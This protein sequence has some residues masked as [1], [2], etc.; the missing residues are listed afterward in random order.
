MSARSLRAAF[1]A[2]LLLIAT[3]SFAQDASAPVST[4]SPQEQRH[5]GQSASPSEEDHSAHQ[6]PADQNQYPAEIPPITDQDRVAAFPKLHGQQSVHDDAV[7]YYVLFDQLEWQT[8][9]GS[10]AGSWDNQGWIGHDINRFWFRAEGEA[11]RGGVAD[12]FADALFGRAIRPFWD[13]V[14]GVRQ[15]F[16]PGPG[17]TWAAVGIQ[18]LAPYW[19]EVEATAY[20]GESWRT[21]FRLE[22]E[23]ELLLTNR[24]I[25]QPRLEFDIYGKSDPER[26]IGAGLSSGEAG[27][28]LRY[29]LRREFAP[30]VGVTWDRSFFGTADLA[31][32]SGEDTD[33]AKL[34]LGRR[35][36][37]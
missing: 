24:L 8:A 22:T 27:L 33:G 7:H 31:Q 19:F 6:K 29:E 34:A 30:Y 35:V 3:P 2:T 32:A 1:A 17:R 20:M 13:V 18:G 23:Y 37:F 16:Q 15:D 14:V 10:T 25:L 28:R 4:Q 12:A 11:E 5:A 26:G 36:W 9:D 21:L